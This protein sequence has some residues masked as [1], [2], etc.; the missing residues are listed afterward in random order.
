[1]LP[2]VSISALSFL[3]TFCL[4]FPWHTEPHPCFHPQSI[5]QARNDT[6][7]L[8]LAYDIEVF[9]GGHVSLQNPCGGQ[10]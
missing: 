1:M 4:L 3:L 9:I 8:F 6:G 10:A 5:L 2:Q 7:I